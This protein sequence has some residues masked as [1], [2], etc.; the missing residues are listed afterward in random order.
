MATICDAD[1]GES[2][3][4]PACLTDLQTDRPQRGN[5]RAAQ[6]VGWCPRHR[7]ASSDDPLRTARERQ[8][9]AGHRRCLRVLVQASPDPRQAWAIAGPIPFDHGA[10]LALNVGQLRVGRKRVTTPGI[11]YRAR[12]DG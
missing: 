4:A 10:V 8:P 5:P 2:S 1:P 9:G 7:W 3:G 12:Q 11:T 6:L